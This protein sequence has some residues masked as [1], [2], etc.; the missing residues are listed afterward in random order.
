MKK[1][2][3]IVVDRYVNIGTPLV[4]MGAMWLYLW[5]FPWYDAYVFDPRWGHNFAEAQAFLA[6]G[7][8][9]FVGRLISKWLAFLASLLIIVAALALLPVAVTA[10][11]GAV[12][13]VLII[14]DMIVER[15]RKDD[16][17][18]PA[19][20]RLTVWL[21]KH[22][23]RF[24]HTLLMHLA[25]IY[26]LVR[27]PSGTYEPDVVTKVF[28]GMTIPFFLLAL[29]E[30]PVKVIRGVSIARVGFFWGMLTILVSILL[31]IDDPATWV[32]LAIAAA[33]TVVP[34]IALV[35]SRVGE[36]GVS[37]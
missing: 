13:L 17:G 15:G 37:D 34:I 31:L 36:E 18:R 29:M 22:L 10:V 33:V 26:F 12:L 16:L 28:D 24:S 32:I 30:Q 1:W 35:L 9:Y 7:L 5:V 4:L 6:V 19:S 2:S 20:R 23:P 11:T 25:L 3:N 21:Q 8:A 14:V 27:L